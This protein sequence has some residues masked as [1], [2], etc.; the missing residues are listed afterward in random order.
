MQDAQILDT[1]KKRRMKMLFNREAAAFVIP[2]SYLPTIISS[3]VKTFATD[4]RQIFINPDFFQ[5][6]QDEDE[7]DFVYFH[8]HI[9]NALGHTAKD[10]PEVSQPHILKI[11]KEIAVNNIVL[12]CG[13]TRPAT[14]NEGIV[15]QSYEGWS[16]L[17]IYKDLCDNAQ[18]IEMYDV[19]GLADDG[20]G[21][22]DGDSNNEG[23]G[24]DG[25]SPEKGCSCCIS[26]EEAKDAGGLPS[27]KL[28][29]VPS[30]AS[31]LRKM[32]ETKELLKD[33]GNSPVAET[34]RGLLEDIAIPPIDWADTLKDAFIKSWDGSCVDLS[35]PIKQYMVQKIFMPNYKD[36][37]IDALF[38]AI[39][40]S[41]SI[42]TEE[43]SKAQKVILEMRDLYEIEEIHLVTYN[44]KIIE[45][46]IFEQYEDIGLG[47]LKGGGGTRGDCVFEMIK[48]KSLSPHAV[49]MISDTEDNIKTDPGD[50]TYP[51]IWLNT[52]GGEAFDS[53]YFNTPEF[54]IIVNI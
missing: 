27:H 48:E 33:I 45:H 16:T 30:M 40:L 6:L 12:Q 4:G 49:L 1:L 47:D 42:T 54:G 2:Y 37:S 20:D 17:K 44:T 3:K 7:I 24:D 15:D 32:A 28:E 43:L 13:F 10:F 5:T 11:A 29:D 52:N 36:D 9:H 35:N 53:E 39:D 50:I 8:E 21:E 46:K 34:V 14:P 18:K 19:S 23:N 41:I 22:G 51:V 26:P 25:D 38:V 31:V